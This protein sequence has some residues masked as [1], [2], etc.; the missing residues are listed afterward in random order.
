[1]INQNQ[2]FSMNLLVSSLLKSALIVV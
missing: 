1:M 2:S